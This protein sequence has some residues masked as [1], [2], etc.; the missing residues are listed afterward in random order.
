MDIYSPFGDICCLTIAGSGMDSP[1]CALEVES[2]MN[3]RSKG[4]LVAGT[5]IVAIQQWLDAIAK[6]WSPIVTR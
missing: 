1:L 4:R 2:R 6:D 3:I 5:W